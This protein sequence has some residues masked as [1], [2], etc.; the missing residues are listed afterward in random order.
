MQD[1]FVPH[2]L[3][4]KTAFITGGTS[5]IN[6]AIARRFVGAGA[7][8]AVVGRDAAKAA[9]A[10][11]QL[12]EA[13]QASGGEAMGLSADVRDYDAVEAAL[14]ETHTRWGALDIVIAGA[15][16]NFVAPVLG[17]SSKGFRTVIDIDL[18]GTF[19]TARAAHAFLRKPGSTLIAISAA[20]SM[21]PVAGQ[22]QVCAAKA[23]IDMLI[24]SLCVEWGPDGVRCLSIAPG[25]VEGTEGM[26]RLAPEGARSL[27]ALL[28]T[29][30]SRR[31]AQLGEIADLALFLVS[32]AADYINGAVIPIEGGQ[33][34]L[35]THAFGE[36]LLAS[37]G[38]ARG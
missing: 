16:G 37:V 26:R 31:Q 38:A 29:I 1:I 30:P 12:A 5:G 11:A 8:V 13:G 10:A 34:N 6:L 20:H 17:M 19:N 9:D 36:M 25:P 14:R 28:S 32:G 23:G 7:R 27:E 15:A 3:R 21:M 35:G 22:A 4:G 24:R 33:L 2:L 18:V